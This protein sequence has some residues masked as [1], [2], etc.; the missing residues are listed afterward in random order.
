M[1]E[2]VYKTK[3]LILWRY[4]RGYIKAHIKKFHLID[5]RNGSFEKVGFKTHK[6]TSRRCV[7]AGS[8]PFFG[9]F[10]TYRNP[11]FAAITGAN[12]APIAKKTY[13]NVN[14]IVPTDRNRGVTSVW[15]V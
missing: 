11:S 12:I 15:V 13:N 2:S 5:T 4:G 8:L 10:L 7:R 1:R 6:G 14:A 9:V 3:K